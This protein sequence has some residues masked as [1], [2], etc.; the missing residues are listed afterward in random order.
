MTT[1]VVGA[2]GA[3]GKLLVEQLLHRGERVRA[4]VRSC[5]KIPA[6]LLEHPLL[7]VVEAS[8]ADATD[9]EI[10]QYVDGCDAIASC[11][12]HN[13]T[14][15][16]VFGHPRRLVTQAV[17]R[18]CHAASKN[19]SD[20]PV[21]FV[22]MN[23]AGNCN[24]DLNESISF[25]EQCVMALL[26]RAVP[27]HRDNELAAEHLRTAIGQNNASLQWSVVRPDTLINEAEVSEYQ[28]HVSPTRSAIFNAGK[29]SRINVAHFMAELISDQATWNRWK[30][31]MPV[32]YNQQ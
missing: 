24:R 11:L 14:L 10:A 6:T 7:S 21:K 28:P 25:A 18:L 4:V 17:Q 12:G 15:K 22:L 30:G 9:G 8:I 2:S 23:T 31:E 13:L 20:K 27:P 5:D 19:G 29:T 32:I 16:G 1:L 3:T 26:R